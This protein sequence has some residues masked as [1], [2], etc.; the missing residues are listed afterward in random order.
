MLRAGRSDP[1][2]AEVV[3]DNGNFSPT[4]TVAQMNALLDALTVP[5]TAAALREVLGV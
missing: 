5:L 4:H 3:F 2:A 1:A